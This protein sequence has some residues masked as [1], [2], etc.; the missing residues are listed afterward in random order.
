[1]WG[2]DNKDINYGKGEPRRSTGGGGRHNKKQQKTM[3]TTKTTKTQTAEHPYQI[4]AN[5]FLRT[6]THHHTGRLVAVHDR[7]LVL[8]NAA[9]IADDGRL[10]QSLATETFNEVELFPVDKQV[11]IGRDSLIDAVQIKTLP[12]SQ[13]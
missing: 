8:E 9:W 4:G 5:Y 13:K 7:E 11:I 6:V 2:F 1:L 10:T 3:K 12:T